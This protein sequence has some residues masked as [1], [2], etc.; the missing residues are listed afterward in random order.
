M[1]TCDE[2]MNSLYE[3]RA[4]YVTAQRKKKKV[5]VS[6]GA[7][8]CAVSLLGGSV[9]YL[10]RPQHDIPVI[11]T[12]DENEVTTTTVAV[13]TEGENTTT[14]TESMVPTTNITTDG[15]I[16]TPPTTAPTTVPA[17]SKPTATQAPTTGKTE[18]P[19]TTPN[20]T[21]PSKTN[22]TQPTAS[23]TKP[24]ATQTKPT[25]LPTTTPTVPQKIVITADEP[26]TYDLGLPEIPLKEYPRISPALQ[27]KM[28]IYSGVDVLYSVIVEV[29][30]TN[31]QGEYINNLPY[32]NAELL[33]LAEEREIAYQEFVDAK[34]QFGWTEDVL[35]K[36]SVFKDIARQYSKRLEELKNEYFSLFIDERLQAFHEWSNQT[37]IPLSTDTRFYPIFASD[38]NHAFF[39]DLTADEINELAKHDGYRIRLVFPGGDGE[40]VVP[41][42]PE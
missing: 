2:M 9:W 20:K 12:P 21:E 18:P 35:N 33:Q 27:E 14:T 16:V 3:R 13:P 38:P 7:T 36:Q 30:V 29:L 39:M 5:L 1:K 24:T 19:K 15:G 23:Q 31:E 34:E 17:P 41:D 4:Q 26:D 32:N 10:N 22:P 28:K 37:L 25:T 8:L 42:M 40:I 6:A 11:P